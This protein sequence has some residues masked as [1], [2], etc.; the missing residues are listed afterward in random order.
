MHESRHCW[1]SL[2]SL[3]FI[4]FNC[5]FYTDSQRITLSC[6]PVWMWKYTFWDVYSF[7]PSGSTSAALIAILHSVTELL[8]SNP[9]V[10]VLALDFS[11]AFDA[12]RHAALFRKMALSNIPDPVY[13]WFVEFLSDQ[14]HCTRY[15]SS[16][17][18]IGGFWR[19]SPFISETVRDS[20]WLLWNVNR[21]SWVPDW[22]VSF[23]M[24]LNLSDP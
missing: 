16:T 5:V 18:K 8:S 23:L 1:C 11:K 21:K 14:R 19:K 22:M 6:V 9:F 15:G 10:V 4:M 13:N 2:F 7:C 24:T 3:L 20:L 17:G 12:I